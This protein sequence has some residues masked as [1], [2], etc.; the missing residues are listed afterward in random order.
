MLTNT[1]DHPEDDKEFRLRQS[2]E[3]KLYASLADVD[4][5]AANASVY[6]SGK[7]F[8]DVYSCLHSLGTILSESPAD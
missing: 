3:P 4:A 5:I 1:L 7:M 6:T 8:G 2:F